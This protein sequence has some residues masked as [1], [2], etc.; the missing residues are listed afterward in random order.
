M[1]KK[2]IQKKIKDLI[3]EPKS[4]STFEIIKNQV[5]QLNNKLYGERND[6]K[7]TL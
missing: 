2:T 5:Q 1:K 3:I 4:Q 7:D 6:T